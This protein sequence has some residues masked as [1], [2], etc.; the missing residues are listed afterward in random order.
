M[1]KRLL[2][3]I[4]LILGLSFPSHAY[5][6]GFYEEY[7]ISSEVN[8]LNL[9]G[10]LRN[11]INAINGGLDNTN[12]EDTFNLVEILGALP[13]AGNEGRPVYLT[14]S[15]TFHFDDGTAWVEVPT[16]SG[17]AV[18]GDI[19]YF[20]GTVWT[21]L[22]IGTAGQF[23]KV[24]TNSPTWSTVT[25]P[26]VATKVV[27]AND[28]IDTSRADYICDGTD[29]DVQIQQAIDAVAAGGVGGKV[30]LLE[31]TFT[32]GSGSILFNSGDENISIEGAGT[33]TVITCKDSFDAQLLS[34]SGSSGN[35]II[36][37]IKFDGNGTNQTNIEMLLID[38]NKVII[39]KCWFED[40]CE[41]GVLLADI[42]DITI[43]DCDFYT[44]G[45][46]DAQGHSIYT[47]G[48]DGN[49]NKRIIVEGCYFDCPGAV[50]TD[51]TKHIYFNYADY[52]HVVNN[53]FY[54]PA[55]VNSNGHADWIYFN[56]C[57]YS[58]IEGNTL[59]NNLTNTAVLQ[60]IHI[61]ISTYCRINDNGIYAI[62][63]G[64]GAGYGIRVVGASTMLTVTGNN[65]VGCDANQGFHD[66]GSGTGILDGNTFDEGYTVGTL[67]DGDNAT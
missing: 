33:G 66:A 63:G 25:F 55:A 14:P 32:L 19:I 16:Y 20:N 50:W 31:G 34:V 48:S 21:R 28:S 2:L 23:L 54:S 5:Q 43:R 36:R 41:E 29:D 22:S 4:F 30:V 67:T 64:G 26:C 11:I 40:N 10:N 15:N 38:D 12:I 45:I 44:Q 53:E 65:T 61:N 39:E 8:Y 1:I 49:E 60:G 3:T 52:S 17:N 18:D 9:N 56:Y 37:N 27:A 24:V 57:D 58:K 13:V 47:Q 46:N 42:D 59:N 51:N 6:I 62:T 35:V 7:G